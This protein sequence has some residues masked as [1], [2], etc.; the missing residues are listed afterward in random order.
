MCVVILLVLCHVYHNTQR[1]I[2][3]RIEKNVE[4]NAFAEI[5]VFSQSSTPHLTPHSNLKNVKKG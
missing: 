5:D 1:S 4:N 2:Q 3:K